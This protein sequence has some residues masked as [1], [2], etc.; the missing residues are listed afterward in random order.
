MFKI[1][2]D[3]KTDE[4]IEISRPANHFIG[5]EGVGGKIFI[6]NQRFVFK[7]HAANI[8]AHELTVPFD[9]II[10]IE[11]Y[12][13]LGIVPNGLK[14]VL[15]SGKTEKFAV[16]KRSIIKQAILNKQKN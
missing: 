4:K 11:F 2:L 14:L 12:N 5:I 8:Q 6:T 13:T 10:K 9:D 3:L 15:A 16:W 1:K 7:S